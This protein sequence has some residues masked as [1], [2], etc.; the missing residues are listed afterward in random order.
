MDNVHAVE[1]CDIR[2]YRQECM[3]TVEDTGTQ[4]TRYVLHT[5]TYNVYTC[6]R[7]YMCV[8]M[9]D[10]CVCVCVCVMC[11]CVCVMCVCVCVYV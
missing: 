2:K 4:K 8:C 3:V 10:V 1:N 5:L 9:C 7:V 11:V 6:V